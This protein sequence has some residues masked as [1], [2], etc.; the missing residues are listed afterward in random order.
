MD[1][2][3]LAIEVSKYFETRLRALGASGK[4]LH[5]LARSVSTSLPEEAIESLYRIARERNR[6]VHGESGDWNEIDFLRL[7]LKLSASFAR[8]QQDTAIQGTKSSASVRRFSVPAK[9]EPS[10]VGLTKEQISVLIQASVPGLSEDELE[11]LIDQANSE[12]MARSNRIY[13]RWHA[14][15]FLADQGGRELGERLRYFALAAKAGAPMDEVLVGVMSKLP[16][17]FL[18]SEF[19]SIE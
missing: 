2:A 4:G 6:V 16:M 3:T 12:A 18:V 7:A 1:Q 17:Q 9:A 19:R 15:Q 5:E 10:V 11:D 8:L 13:E 14:F